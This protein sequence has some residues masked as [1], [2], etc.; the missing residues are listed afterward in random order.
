MPLIFLLL[1][2]LLPW[3]TAAEEESFEF[4]DE[5]LESTIEAVNEG[6]LE[7]LL[8]PPTESVHHHI[9]RIR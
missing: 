8:T 7:F 1:L 4:P 3:C 6:D 9:N 5:D 2:S